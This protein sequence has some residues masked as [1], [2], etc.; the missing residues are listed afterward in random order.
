MV[1]VHKKIG[2]GSSSEVFLIEEAAT[3]CDQSKWASINGKFA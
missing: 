2:E 1:K 3:Q